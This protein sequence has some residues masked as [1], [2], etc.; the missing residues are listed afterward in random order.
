MGKLNIAIDGPA[1]A[2]KSTMAR[3]IANEL[4]II[5]L[6][7]GAMYR[8]VALKAIRSGIG[9]SD[10]EGLAAMMDDLDIEVECIGDGQV[11]RLD[12][13]NVNEMIRTP[14]VTK[15]TRSAVEN[16]GHPAAYRQPERSDHG[17][18]GHRL[19]CAAGRGC[20]DLSDC[21]GRRKGD[22]AL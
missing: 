16:G 2:G 10:R 13:Q 14:E 9:T 8:T 12:G 15:G 19:L 1:G 22:A 5:Y 21:I 11:I 17:R 6:D 7:T 4:G 18:T 20:E 3:I